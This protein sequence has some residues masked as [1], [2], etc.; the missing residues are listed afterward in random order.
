[1]PKVKISE[2]SPTPSNN[3]DIDGINIA[4]GCAPS[5][6]ND[7]IRELMSQLKDFQAGTAGDSFNGP[8]GTTTAA[9][10]V[11]TTLSASGTLGVTGVATLG[12]GAIL[13]TPA[14]VTL[15]NATGL[16]IA[17]GVSG[18]G[19]G[20]ATALAVNVGSAGAP[21]VNGGA[22]G[23]P[24]SGTV[25]N[26]TGTA[27]ININGTVGAT[28]ASTGAFTT[29]TTSSTVTHNGGTANGVAFLN[30]SKVL[31]TG[32][33]LTFNG[34]TLIAPQVRLSTGGFLLDGGG[35]IILNPA[36]GGSLSLTSNNS[37]TNGNIVYNA[38][39]ASGL[40][41]WQTNTAEQMRL[42]S[43]GLGIGTS[44]PSARLHSVS[45]S[46]GSIATQLLLSNADNTDGTGAQITFSAV[47]GGTTPTGSLTN[48]RD[49]SG[50]Y[51]LRFATFG[52]GTNTERMRLDASGNLGLGV[53][54]SAWG[55]SYKS[56]A[57]NNGGGSLVGASRGI[58]V[59]NNAFNDNTNWVYVAN[60]AA[61][62]YNVNSGVHS[63]FTAPS[64]TAGN[65]I[66]FTQALTLNAS[67]QL[68]TGIAGSASAPSF[69]RT[70]DL[71]TGI[72]FPAADTIAF[73]EGGVESMRIDSSGNLGIGTSSPGAKLQVAWSLD[74]LKFTNPSAGFKQIGA[75]Y[76]GYVSGNDYAAIILG[77]DGSSGG[78]IQFSVT[79]NGGSLTTAATLDQNGNLGLGV[80]PSAWGFAG[81]LQ[82]V[83]G[84]AIGSINKF[85]HFVANAYFN[86]GWKYASTASSAAR[87]SQNDGAHEWL[88]APSGTAGN[89]I[90]FTQAMTLDA[91]GNLLLGTTTQAG[92]L[93]VLTNVDNGNN[94]DYS[95]TNIALGNGAYP[96]F[97][98]ARRFGASY[99]NGLD[100]YYTDGSTGTSTL[101]AR[102]DS[103]GNML[104]GTTT[105]N[106]GS[107]GFNVASNGQFFS[108]TDSATN[109]NLRR[110]ASNG[111]V[112]TFTPV[113][114]GVVGAIT[115][116]TTTTTYNTS[117]DYRLKN[118]IVPMTGALAKV[119]LLKPCT[120]KWN[121]D[122]SDGEGFIAHEL[123]EVVPQCVTG[124]KDAVDAEGKPQYQGI[125]TS[126]L[127]ATLTAAIQELKA[128][129]DA[130]KASHP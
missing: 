25:T 101:G 7:A 11:F 80:T 54:P 77:T 49:G 67:G 1:M 14:S 91:S 68:E 57:L 15:T 112:A 55:S 117:S 5:G 83:S 118:T 115:I 110:V 104:I 94:T 127:V 26:L 126:F 106:R 95:Q 122:G 71:N 66:T 62:R 28:T 79:P 119:A 21:V 65:A 4:E 59:V 123:A 108:S 52:G 81:N 125:D 111:D 76:T 113:G 50:S 43:T 33:A 45:T 92:K 128:E 29:L 34:T 37:F 36:S 42:N 116:G 99:A 40:H 75:S 84:G 56:L 107:A 88:T 35:N 47:S 121:A 82:F 44:S 22:L 6:I 98:K 69:T 74:Q 3:T 130:Y 63:W 129:F 114:G 78:K 8:I 90:S 97:I 64:G 23:T 72:F 2:F 18:L 20:V 48:V 124:E 27:S 58:D 96:V 105:T 39:A 93:N 61:A 51:S 70:G 109:L 60:A 103:S 100:F 89:A 16:P 73:S 38:N 19:T 30:G 12:N 46:A 86:S 9:A 85:S 13:G 31:T 102:I 24:S 53:T 41:V 32:S 17:T 87:Y 120:Y 10:G